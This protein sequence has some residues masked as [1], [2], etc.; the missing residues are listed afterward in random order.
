MQCDKISACFAFKKLFFAFHK[1]FDYMKVL[2]ELQ[3][4]HTTSAGD[5]HEW[6]IG[7]NVEGSLYALTRWLSWYFSEETEETHKRGMRKAGLTKIGGI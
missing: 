4:L 6:W 7:K 2:Q 5:A 3:N 1:F